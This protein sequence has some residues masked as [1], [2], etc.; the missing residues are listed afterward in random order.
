MMK[1]I[2]W[3][4]LICGAFLLLGSSCATLPI[5]PLRPGEVRL[6]GIHI[7]D[8]EGMI[9][10]LQYSVDLNFEAD[11]KPEMTRTCFRWSGDG[12]YCYKVMNVSYGSPG[13]VRVPLRIPNKGSYHLE[14][15]VFY[16]KD[17]KTLMTNVISSQV[18]VAR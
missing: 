10:N 4:I 15:Y 13:T 18:T 14:G 16:I 3:N 8:V 1:S 11:G 2:L 9:A 5:E 12:P 7:P 6:I 17:G